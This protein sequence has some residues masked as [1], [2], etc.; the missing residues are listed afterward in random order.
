M[1][2]R[3]MSQKPLPH[4]KPTAVLLVAWLAVLLTSFFFVY[5]DDEL[6]RSDGYENVLIALAVLIVL[7]V[8]ILVV[9]VLILKKPK[10]KERMI[11]KPGTYLTLMEDEEEEEEEIVGKDV[12]E[13]S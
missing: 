10:V 4:S 6:S 3:Q 5:L 11:T 7:A 8:A 12:H 13:S 2:N 9:F 1:R